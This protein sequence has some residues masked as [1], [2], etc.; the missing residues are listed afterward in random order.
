M[1]DRVVVDGAGNIYV[2]GHTTA[3]DFPTTSGAYRTQVNFSCERSGT[4]SSSDGFLVKFNSSGQRVWS[5]YLGAHAPAGF[6]PQI[7]G[8]NALGLDASGNVAVAGSEFQDLCGNS[9]FMLKLNSSGSTL[10]YSNTLPCN[11]NSGAGIIPQAAAVDPSGRYF[12]LAVSDTDGS[13]PPTP[14][15]NPADPSSPQERLVKV[16]TLK[17][18]NGG[19]VY[20]AGTKGT[21]G[22]VTVN[23]SGN[24]YVVSSDTRVTKFDS[25][26][27]ALFSVNYLPSWATSAS[28]RAIILTNTGDVLFTGQVSPQGA[29]P[30]T[31]SFGTTTSGSA[32]TDTLIVRL[33]G[34]TGSRVYSS[35]IHDVNMAPFALARDSANEAFVTGKLSASW[36]RVNPYSNAPLSGA[37]L[38]HLNSTGTSVWLDSAFGGDAGYGIAVDSAWNAYVVGTSLSGEYFPLTANAFQSSFKGATAQGF[39]SKLIIEADLKLTAS[40]SP[41]PVPHGTNLTYTFSV[42]N[43]GP[44]VSDGDT[45]TDVLPS[46]TT[47][48]SFTNTNGTCT[49]PAVGSGGTFKCTRSSPLLKGHSWGPIKLTVLV[50]AAPGTLTNKASVAAK[51]QD[52][53]SSNNTATVSVTV[54]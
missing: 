15:A 18:T 7:G 33:N 52:V 14:G 19:V 4:C 23:S 35:A 37:F 47:F 48:V 5:T 45:L 20:V 28:G 32:A 54:K 9:A 46:G 36:F 22:G 29:Y 21:S 51:T 12:Y 43:N 31:T 30:A 50:N 27:A 6:S 8:I 41:N 42:L 11:D 3:I 34:S 26:G 10:V 38:V 1:A 17:T 44:D 39:L 53:V 24:A 13:Y 49:H 25:L 40:A 16:D 2:A